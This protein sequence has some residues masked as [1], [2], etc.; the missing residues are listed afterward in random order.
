MD[1]FSTSVDKKI[2]LT[3]ID[4][5][6]SFNID[7]NLMIPKEIST[8]VTIYNDKSLYEDRFY[9]FK[10]ETNFQY[11]SISLIID[12]DIKFEAVKKKENDFVE[13]KYKNYFAGLFDLTKITICIINEN[14]ETEFYQSSYFK[15]CTNKVPVEIIEKVIDEVFNYNKDLL[16][17]IISTNYRN[18]AY[19]NK[20]VVTIKALKQML[21]EFVVVLKK[22]YNFFRVQPKRIIVT[23]RKVLDTS[24]ITR[25]DCQSVQSIFQNLDD[26]QQVEYKSDICVKNKYY[27]SKRIVGI[28]KEDSYEV[29]ENKI[30]MGFIGELNTY[31]KHFYKEV[32]KQINLLNMDKRDEENIQE[33]YYI[34]NNILNKLKLKIYENILIE[35]KEL[36]SEYEKIFFLYSNA[37][38]TKEYTLLYKPKYTDTFRSVKHYREIFELIAR[39]FEYK[40]FE[41]KQQGYMLGFKSLHT[42]YEYYCLIKILEGYESQ[43]YKITSSKC[44]ED[45]ELSKYDF[46]ISEYRKIN[47]T[48]YLIKENT[49]EQITIYYHP[50]IYSKKLPNNNDI[51]LLRRDGKSYYEPDYLI[52]YNKNGKSL[53]SIMDAKF[54]TVDN[55]KNYYYQNLTYKY[56]INIGD[57]NSIYSTV[58]NLSAL[59]LNGRS[60]WKLQSNNSIHCMPRVNLLIFSPQVGEEQMHKYCKEVLD[61]FKEI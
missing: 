45:Y 47:N 15:I 30:V 37:L 2:R 54:S 53:Y 4:S 40:D 42:V 34:P 50:K 46:E 18:I 22:N 29:Y 59:C 1:T 56:L 21:E 61:D 41:F 51:S 39:F 57:R 13:T 36:K 35:I 12:N 6:S 52:K 23:N 43:G 60:E 5:F 24:A 32:E 26:V 7:V 28:K 33:H 27:V 20:R 10:I 19:Q 25:I 3:I 48:F 9:K 55:V 11:K 14:D 58:V 16:Q 17:C 8:G 38:N 49:Q 44:Y 31:V